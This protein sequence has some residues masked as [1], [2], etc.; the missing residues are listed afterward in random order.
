MKIKCVHLLSKPEDKRERRSIEQLSSL[1]K[2]G[3]EICEIIN[4]P[5]TGELPESR[6][7]TDRPFQ[8]TKGMYGCWK[9]H[10]DAITEHLRDVD[11][12]LVC[13]CDC[14][15]ICST[16]DFVRRINRAAECCVNGTLD[17]FTLGYK[18][19]GKTLDKVG[20]DVIVISQWIETHCYLVPIKSRKL[21]LEM[22]E[23]PW[24]TFDYCTTV[25]L[26]DQQRCR[27]G[28]FADRPAAIQADGTSL[29]DG[30]ERNSENHYRTAR[31]D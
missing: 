16:E 14:L 18:H 13:E 1:P 30:S 26:Y 15:P 19:D 20:D 8:L 25:Y 10:K 22:F 12:L 5:W 6:Y 11:A 17:A 23:K 27:I 2:Y 9:A 24:D 4:P 29:T 28:A 3:I 21:F 31:H 7:A